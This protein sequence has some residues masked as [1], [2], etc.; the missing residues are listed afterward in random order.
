MSGSQPPT[1]SLHPSNV[2]GSPGST[3]AGIGVILASLGQVLAAGALPT[4]PAGWIAIALQVLVGAG[5][6]FGK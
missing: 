4:T 3:F 2:T 1:S 6:A 5:A